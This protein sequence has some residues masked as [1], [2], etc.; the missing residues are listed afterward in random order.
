MSK[1][2]EL[3]SA[4]FYGTT[5]IRPTMGEDEP[6][7]RPSRLFGVRHLE[8]LLMFLCL[9]VAYSLRVNLS[10]AIVAMMD[11]NGTGVDFPEY[12]WDNTVKAN[13]LTSF[14]WGY[15]VTQLPAGQL[16][17]RFGPKILLTGSLF[18][19]SLFTIL[20]PVAA[21]VGDW[22]LVC[23]TRV[24]QGLAQGFIF[25]SIHTL[26][27]SW[28]PTEERGR[29]GTYVYAGGQVGTIIA[30]PLS[31]A[32]ASS[33]I[34]WPS[35]FYIFGALGI[36]WVLLWVFLGADRPATHR[37]ISKA[38]KAYIETNLG[39]T[40]STNMKR[41][42]P[43][44]DIFTSLPMWAVVIAHCGQNWGFWTLLTEMPSYMNSILK[45]D[46]KS[47]GL[48]SALPYLVMWLMSF[49]FSWASDF[50][51]TRR[52]ISLGTSRKIFNSIG[53]WIPGLALIGLTLSST[54]DTTAA[55][56][57][58]TLAVGV[59]S[60]AYV[61]FQL[62][63]IDLSPNYSGTMMGITNCLSNIMSI[64]APLVV[65]FIVTDEN[66]ATQWKTVFYISSGIYFAGNLFFVLFG[67][68]EIQP[69]NEPDPP[70][71]TDRAQNIGMKET[72]EDKKL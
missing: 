62:N 10:V 36:C 56:A 7:P 34:G 48:L 37:F 53:H 18:V 67:K 39:S 6:A 31:G 4:K 44:I 49:V 29:F 72:H 5:A 65:G 22:G 27:S 58:L 15:V 50:L 2:N 25:P 16:A 66:D 70:K 35:I 38:E 20:L 21:E 55:V 68:A 11:R 47:N 59:N 64:I 54:D 32:L 12:H 30:M 71:D 17:Q 52:I 24:I 43:W 3:N 33:S 69:W 57:L 13:I 40:L 42:T 23:G 60:A 9:A 19:C 45:F 8:I 26:L 1:L 46:L 51:N 61:G 14:F 41:Q 28:T 63:H